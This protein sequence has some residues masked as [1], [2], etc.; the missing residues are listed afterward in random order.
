[1]DRSNTFIEYLV[2]Q[3]YDGK[4]LKS[5]EIKT[6]G[7]NVAGVLVLDKDSKTARI[8]QAFALMSDKERLSHRLFPFYRTMDW[9]KNNE[10]VNPA[11]SIATQ[12]NDGSWT[13]YDAHDS[14]KKRDEDCLDYDLAQ[15]RFR[16]RIDVK[17]VQE[18]GKALNYSCWGL[19]FLVA[20]YF[21]LS[22]L[23]PELSF[24]VDMSVVSLFVL[25]A[26][27]VVLPMI[28]PLIKGLSLFGIDFFFKGND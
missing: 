23:F 25:V 20:V 8:I 22:L 4:A 18:I 3:G 6:R 21:T 27:L 17:P 28:I 9:G 7:L 11:C 13:I 14:R 16:N 5:K 2:K 15:K 12:N 10:S 19:A 1:M 24:P 26:V